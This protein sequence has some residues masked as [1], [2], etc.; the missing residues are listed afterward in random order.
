[1]NGPH[2]TTAWVVLLD[3]PSPPQPHLTGCIE[4]A[5]PKEKEDC[6]LITIITSSLKKKKALRDYSSLQQGH[7]DGSPGGFCRAQE[8]NNNAHL[9]PTSALLQRASHRGLGTGE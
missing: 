1:M 5:C 7:T 6:S 4:P 8:L 9:Q 3:L 2:P